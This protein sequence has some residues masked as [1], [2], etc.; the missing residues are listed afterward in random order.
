MLESAAAG[1][2]GELAGTLTQAAKDAAHTLQAATSV[3]SF[4]VSPVDTVQ[5]A[6]LVV[7]QITSPIHTAQAVSSVV[8]HIPAAR[9]IY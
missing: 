8:S 4:L 9:N 3:V 6:A 1:K 5:A 7:S 2:A